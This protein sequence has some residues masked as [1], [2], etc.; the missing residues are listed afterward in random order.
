[1]SS[2]EQRRILAVDIGGGTQDI[3][4]YEAWKNPENSIKLV[5][6]S[7]TVLAADRIAQATAR[8]QA[9]YLSGTI[10]GGGKSSRA[11]KNHLK[12]G[13]PVYAALEA[14]KTIHDDLERV[15]EMGVI[16]S[17]TPPQEPVFHLEMKDLDLAALQRALQ[18]FDIQLP[19][20]IAAAVQDHGEAPRGVSNRLFRFQHWEAFI[21]QG[22]EIEQLAYFM[23]PPYMTRM[24]ALQQEAPGALVMDTC[25]AAVWGALLDPEIKK[26]LPRGV[27]ILNVGNQ[28]TFAALVK[29]RRIL[30]I[31]EHHTGLMNAQKIYYL[32]NK[33]RYG[34]L[35][36]EEVFSDGGHGCSIAGPLESV[37][38]FVG[39][40]GPRRCIAAELNYH[41]ANPCGDM[42]M[43]G[44][45]GLVQ[46]LK[47]RTR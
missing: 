2:R 30:G 4:L 8:G 47:N 46:A 13:L 17:D 28:H 24:Q 15:Q 9:I 34:E 45:Y 14:A 39:V 37:F 21:Q 11:I 19:A 31:F 25:S 27:V 44:C 18:N 29:E 7:P 43:T 41:P 33:L 3:L 20:E 40:T 16:L 5:L 12:Q 6:P 22:G 42:M 1:M 36:H 26:A 38:K 10:M 32:V 35:T 23:P